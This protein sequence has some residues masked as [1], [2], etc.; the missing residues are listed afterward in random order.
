[1]FTLPDLDY[2]YNALLPVLSEQQ[3]DAHYN[4]HYASYI[5][6]LNTLLKRSNVSIK[7]DL[8]WIVENIELFPM[9][10]R[11]DIL[12]NAMAALNHNLYFKSMNPKNRRPVG[13]LKNQ[14][15][16]QY[17]NYENF[18]QE[19]TKSSNFVVGSGYTFLVANEDGQLNIMNTSNQDSPYLYNYIPLITIDLWEHSYYL[20]Y[21]NRRQDYIN[22]FFSIIDFEEASNT[23]EKYF[24]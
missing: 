14:I 5:K 7:P 24:S 16:S 9:E 4:L 12:Y 2:A 8:V 23:Y 20:D 6:K 18:K 17:G 15:E 11:D 19:M 3:I 10:I 1:M 21:L 13:K 22:N